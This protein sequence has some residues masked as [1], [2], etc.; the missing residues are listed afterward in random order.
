MLIE[1]IV[2]L[3]VCV[4]LPITIVWLTLRKKMNEDNIRKDIILAVLEKN[5]EVD[6][7]DLIKKINVS[8]GL[9]KEKLLSK[10]QAGIVTFLVGAALLGFVF[11]LCM[12]GGIKTDTICFICLAGVVLLAVGT[13]FLINYCVGK[14]MLANEM[15]AELKA[16]KLGKK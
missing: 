11:W 16:L 5:V 15:E 13:A 7:E 3:G 6:I 10:Q 9:L 12:I 1:I 14:R 2:P 8:N 4:V